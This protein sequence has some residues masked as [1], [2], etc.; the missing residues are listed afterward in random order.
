M[1]KLCCTLHPALDLLHHGPV[2]ASM[3]MLQSWMTVHGVLMLG[4]V[5][6]QGAAYAVPYNYARPTGAFPTGRGPARQQPTH[7]YPSRPI[8]DIFLLT[9]NI[10][11]R[12]RG[13][14]REGRGERLQG[15]EGGREEQRTGGGRERGMQ[16]G[17]Q[18]RFGRVDGRGRVGKRPADCVDMGHAINRARGLQVDAQAGGSDGWKAPSTTADE[19][20][21]RGRHGEWQEQGRGGS[22]PAGLGKSRTLGSGGKLWGPRGLRSGPK[23][24]RSGRGGGGPRGLQSF[25]LGT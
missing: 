7:N 6:K 17:E 14:E 15:P 23:D 22:R 10:G 20:G 9:G 5:S 2:R 8:A 12:G 19:A 18:Q 25:P 4:Q 11:G 16:R 1:V 13:Q 24:P 21:T 3:Q